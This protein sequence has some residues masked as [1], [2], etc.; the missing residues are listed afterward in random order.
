[1][2]PKYKDSNEKILAGTG[3]VTGFIAAGSIALIGHIEPSTKIAGAIGLIALVA[4]HELCN[5]LDA[6][7]TKEEGLL[8]I[9]AF[10]D[11]FIMTSPA[12]AAG[13][14]MGVVAMAF[15][16]GAAVAAGLYQA[17]RFNVIEHIKNL[18]IQ[19]TR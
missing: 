10:A 1:M 12:I 8:T 6:K 3:L 4:T 19:K 16:S 5:K 11:G 2:K 13:F 7:H 15:T 14:D 18:K 17:K 9:K